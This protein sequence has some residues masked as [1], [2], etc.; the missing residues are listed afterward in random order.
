MRNT[1][2]LDEATRT[3]RWSFS[4]QSR[5]DA[6]PFFAE[7][8]LSMQMANVMALPWTVNLNAF[9]YSGG[10]LASGASVPTSNQTN[11]A[12][13]VTVR[14]Y[15][16][17][18]GSTEEALIDYPARGCTF[19]LQ[20]SM[21]RL[22][23]FHQGIV[24]ATAPKL[25]GF[26][27]PNPRVIV[28]IAGPTFTAVVTLAALAQTNVPIPVRA[29]AYRW[30]IVNTVVAAN[31]LVLEQ[32]AVDA[33]AVVLCQRD[34]SAPFVGGDDQ[35]QGNRAGYI[36]INSIAQFIRLTNGNLTLSRSFGIQFLLDLG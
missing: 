10:L 7:D 27:S 14:V 35:L 9:Q 26:L 25:S 34:F 19:Q 30:F 22:S 20:A 11:S 12:Q 3:G 4:V 15:W 1:A 29:V 8:L 18:D 13:R 21:L 31:D 17:V 28:P 6:T 5:L 16:G 23:L 36:P 32:L 2:A 24:G 33:G